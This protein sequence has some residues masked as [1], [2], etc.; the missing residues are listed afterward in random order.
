MSQKNKQGSGVYQYLELSGV[1][2]TG[3]AEAIAQK[4]KE[5][6]NMV[7]R[8]WKQE[9]RVRETEFKVYLTDAELQNIAKGAR[10]HHMSRTTYIKQAAWAYTAKKY[11]VV[12][13]QTANAIYQM[14]SF[15]FSAITELIED[16]RVARDTGRKLIQHMTQMQQ[17]ILDHLTNPETLEAAI[18]AAITEDPAYKTTLIAMLE[19]QP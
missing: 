14:L 4:R 3:T 11:L 10:Q 7:K 15:N 9:K 2:D 8:K 6:W 17:C 13:E 18:C 12:N 16:D 5:Y 19:T 1:L